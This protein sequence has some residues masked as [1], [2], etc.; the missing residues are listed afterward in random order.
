[1]D[2]SLIPHGHLTVGTVTEL[3]EIEQVSLTAYRIGSRWIAFRAI[4]GAYRPVEPLITFG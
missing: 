4:H 3:G 2:F 1:M